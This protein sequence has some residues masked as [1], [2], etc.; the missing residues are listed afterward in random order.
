MQTVE[1]IEEKLL[2][3]IIDQ[4]DLI[5][6]NDDFNT[7]DF[8]IDALMTVCKHE[9]EQATQC[10]Y[11][12]HFKGK[13]QVKRGIYKELESMCSALLERGITAQIK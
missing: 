2:E 9:L 6:Y 7:F 8:V 5:I 1:E 12:I 13:C 3:E 11:I 10:T 4:R